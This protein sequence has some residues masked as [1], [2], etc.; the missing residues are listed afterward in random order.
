MILTRSL[1]A[2]FAVS[3]M[4]FGGCPDAGGTGGVISEATATGP[5]SV[6]VGGT[7]KLSV[8]VVGQGD[9]S[10]TT[11]RWYQTSGRVVTLDDSTIAEP[12]FVAPSLASESTIA[13]RVDLTLSGQLSSAEVSMRIAADPKHGLDD[14]GSVDEDDAPF[15]QVR[16]KT[17]KGDI[18]LEL[19]REKAPVSVSNFL[20]YVDSRFY[21]RTV[22]HRVVPDFVIQG[23]GFTEDLTQK[24]TRDPILNES[25]N[26][27]KNIRGSLAMARLNAPNTATAQFY[28]NLIDNTSLNRTETNPGYAVFGRVIVG[29]DVVDEIA[30]VETGSEGSLTDVPLEDIVITVAERTSGV[31]PE[32]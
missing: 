9:L 19:D 24:E 17:S 23:G 7:A 21:N 16:L 20:K 1:L 18:V 8:A 5:E 26:G 4:V 15:P 28:I 6:D 30:E 29:L 31:T 13:F 2:A 12:S 10:G 14:S 3:L 32:D 11:Y 27:L 25:T 22:F